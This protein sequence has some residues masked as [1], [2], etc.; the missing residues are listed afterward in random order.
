[1]NALGRGDAAIQQ[2]IA[3]GGAASRQAFPP[4]IFPTAGCRSLGGVCQI[5]PAS[6][7]LLLRV[8]PPA[9]NTLIL[10][11]TLSF[12]STNA[13]S[14]SE[15][16]NGWSHTFKRHLAIAGSSNLEITAGDGSMFGYSCMNPT[17]GFY[18]PLVGNN[19]PV[20]NSLSSPQRLIGPFT[21][22]RPD[23]WAYYYPIE[24]GL[25]ALI[26][27]AGNRWT[28]SY[29]TN[30]VPNQITDPFNRTTTLAYN[31]SGKLSAIQDPTGRITSFTVNSSGNLAQ[32]TTPEL[33]VYSLVYDG[34]NRATAWI[35][36]LGDRTSYSFDASSRVDKRPVPAG[37]DHQSD[38][39][40]QPGGRDQSARLHQHA[41]FHGRRR[42]QFGHRRRWH[43]HVILVG[44]EH[45][46]PFN[47]R[48]SRSAYVVFLCD[49]WQS[50]RES[51]VGRSA[52]GWRTRGLDFRIG[53]LGRFI[54]QQTLGIG[55]P[56]V[57]NRIVYTLC[58]NGSYTI[59]FQGS[60][61]P[62]HKGYKDSKLVDF[63]LQESIVGPMF[64]G[65][66]VM[67]PTQFAKCQGKVSPT[68]VG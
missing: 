51:C 28:V 44:R 6:G 56:Y 63:R 42:A 35:N 25:Q 41:Q 55:I 23:G 22:T 26:N 65:Q 2:A 59:S 18:Q 31:S 67:S 68:K 34:S 62:S 16:G 46:A 64:A 38:L 54:T 36:P 37:T 21:E 5:N 8:T 7:N 13:A 58:C 45:P 43:R 40:D 48:R 33:C 47:R 66:T 10:L 20:Q 19:P 11:P 57:T 27:P 24:G 1:M 9:G 39:P 50:G 12:N 32:I 52:V 60:S 49:P 14:A 61:F 15:V 53:L 4:L 29:N 30:G 3:I 17:N